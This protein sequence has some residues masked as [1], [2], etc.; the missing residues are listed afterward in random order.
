MIRAD[1]K[2]FVFLFHEGGLRLPPILVLEIPEVEALSENPKQKLADSKG[3]E[4]GRLRV[5]V[6]SSSVKVF[7][8]FQGSEVIGDFPIRLVRLKLVQSSGYWK[9]WPFPLLAS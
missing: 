6:T 4:E 2:G 8:P 5:D 3:K 1:D 9:T 7:E